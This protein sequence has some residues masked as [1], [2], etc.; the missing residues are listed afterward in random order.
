LFELY[1]A[2]KVKP[3]IEQRFPLR[4]AAKA[5]RELG[6]RRTVGKLILVP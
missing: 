2:G 4:D 6:E 3:V 5:L 1:A